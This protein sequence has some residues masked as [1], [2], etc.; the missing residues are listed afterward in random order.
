MV[1]CPRCGRVFASRISLRL[2][3]CAPGPGISLL[4][5]AQTTVLPESKKV[6]FRD[7]CNLWKK[8][9]EDESVTTNKKSKQYL[10]KITKLFCSLNED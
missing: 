7:L 1:N 3:C 8:D 5:L 4:A 9:M 10:K 2:H 6:R